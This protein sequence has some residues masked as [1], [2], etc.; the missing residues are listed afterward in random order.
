MSPCI[1]VPVTNDKSIHSAAIHNLTFWSSSNNVGKKMK[2]YV[3]ALTDNSHY[4]SI[5][6]DL[7]SH[8]SDSLI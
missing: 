4:F 6:I 2:L 5:E 7:H 1:F 3:I 8:P